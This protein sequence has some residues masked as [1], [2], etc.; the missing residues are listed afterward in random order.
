M[1][2]EGP[3]VI[4]EEGGV[5]TLTLHRPD[6]LNALNAELLSALY[7]QVSS[8]EARPAVSRPRALIITGSGERA[9]VAGA[10]V[11]AM[12]ELTSTQA[13]QF[14]QLGQRLGRALDE[15]SFPSLAAVNGFALGGGCEL[16]LCCDLILAAER[17][18]FGQ[19]E[20]NLG[21]MPG[22]GATLRLAARVG[23]GRAR[24]L[25]YTGEQLDAATALELG[26][27]DAVFPDGELMTAARELARG[28]A[29]KAPLAVAA[30][31]R[32]LLRAQRS[33]PTTATD[34]ES[35]AFAGLFATADGREGIG[36]FLA[37]RTP[38]FTAQ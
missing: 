30:C 38:R 13:R 29:S 11:A 34:Y 31:K 6:K 5:V 3:L 36:A 8:L 27:A 33:D 21:L 15:A 25:L 1:T 37:K 14:S 4:E 23:I 17:A 24:R 22:F 20:V 19:P 7:A 18:R 32:S 2:V 35:E 28:I 16:A 9:F 26:L 10:D 12:S